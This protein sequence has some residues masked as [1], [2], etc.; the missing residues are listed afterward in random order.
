MMKKFFKVLDFDGRAFQYL[1]QNSPQISESRIKE[2]N[3]VG[4]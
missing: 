4:P 1:L 3:F 2:G